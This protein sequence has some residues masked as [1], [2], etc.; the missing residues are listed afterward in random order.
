[1]YSGHWKEIM[2]ENCK[3]MSDDEV[4]MLKAQKVD[5]AMQM[6]LAQGV[7]DIVCT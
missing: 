5:S 7:K 2:K 3:D 6:L 4:L 1:M